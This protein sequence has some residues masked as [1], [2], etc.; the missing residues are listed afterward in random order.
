[1]RERVVAPLAA[2]ARD[3]VRDLSGSA[4]EAIGEERA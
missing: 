1:M 2:V 3:E 4:V